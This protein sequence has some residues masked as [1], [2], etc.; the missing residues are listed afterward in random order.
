[1]HVGIFYLTTKGNKMD[2][3]SWVAGFLTGFAL[4]PWFWVALL[5]IG[6]SLCSL[7]SKDE[8]FWSFVFAVALVSLIVSKWPAIALLLSTPTAIVSAIVLY[9]IAGTVW[10]LFKW[11]MFVNEQYNKTVAF[12]NDFLKKHGLPEDYFST[13]NPSIDHVAELAK[14]I[15][16]KSSFYIFYPN[17]ISTYSNLCKMLAPTASQHKKSIV[18][19]IAYWPFSATWFVVSDMVTQ[20]ASGIY[21]FIGKQFQSISNSKFDQM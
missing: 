16:D 6:T 12:R 13:G 11:K 2:A 4:T 1:M 10:G 18:M 14:Y 17:A 9:F 3:F 21:N 5:V 8:G 15:A 19:W 20:I 7:S